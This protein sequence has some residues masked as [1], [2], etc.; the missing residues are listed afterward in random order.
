MRAAFVTIVL[1]LLLGGGGTFLWLYYGGFGGEQGS[2]VAFIDMYGEY[3]EVADRVETLVHMPG[4]AGNRDRAELF[5][6]LETILTEQIEDARRDSLARLAY[7]NLE[8]LR[9]EVDAAQSAQA[10]LYEVLQD[11]DNA[12]RQFKAIDLQNHTGRL[13]D[14][15][16]QR[17]ALSARITSV[18]S[19]IND[20]T[21][22]IITRILADSGALTSDHAM[23]I[24]AVT[25]EAAE[26]HELLTTLHA[27][28]D[29]L[30]QEMQGSFADFAQT[31]I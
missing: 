23:Q 4:T 3:A 15:A 9:N 2:A 16:R 7:S 10:E 22:A 20:Q 14:L 29:A 11:L 21:Y 25:D 8:V 28:L 18:Q 31:A 12:S 5:A 24:N 30:K 13:V 26:R 19:E 6:L 1:A 17:A 27:D